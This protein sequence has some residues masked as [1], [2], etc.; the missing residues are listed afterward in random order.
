MD[1]DAMD[2]EYVL[3]A[4]MAMEGL[5]QS[6]IPGAHWVEYFPILRHVPAWFPGAKFRRI[7][8]KFRPY[9]EDMVYKPY[10]ETLQAVVSFLVSLSMTF[11]VQL[12][13]G[14]I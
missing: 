6:H 8:E 2:D 5:G 9:V 7:A 3:L 11:C 10:N 13:S 12:G 1:V 14:H 4:E